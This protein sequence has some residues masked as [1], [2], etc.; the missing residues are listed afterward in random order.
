MTN[1]EIDQ[2]VQRHVARNHEVLKVL[3]SKGFSSEDSIGAEYH[4]WVGEHS[5][6]VVLANELYGDGYLILV[7]SPMDEGEMRR[8]NVEVRKNEVIKEIVSS[9]N[10]SKFVKLADRFRGTFDGWGASG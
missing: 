7:L 1:K 9:D 5:D 6:A 2:E 10:M 3:E 4:F 8:W